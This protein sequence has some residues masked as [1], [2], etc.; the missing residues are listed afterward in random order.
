MPSVYRPSCRQG[1]VTATARIGVL[2]CRH[3]GEVIGVYE[4]LI[5]LIDGAARQ[6]SLAAEPE[7]HLAPGEHYHAACYPQRDTEASAAP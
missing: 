5:V 2:R 3:C 1:P 4:P 6:S 7:S